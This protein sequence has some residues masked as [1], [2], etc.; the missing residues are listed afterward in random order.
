MERE[1]ILSSK[2]EKSEIGIREWTEKQHFK[3]LYL[4]VC[5]YL[6]RGVF[7]MFPYNILMTHDLL[8]RY[9]NLS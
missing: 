5:L 7:H 4:D 3:Q 2:T 9:C 6:I 1:K 8:L